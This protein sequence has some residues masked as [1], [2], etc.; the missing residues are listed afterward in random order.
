ML[1]THR[2]HGRWA[3]GTTRRSEAL[4]DWE[5]HPGGMPRKPAIDDGKLVQVN[6]DFEKGP[7]NGA[8]QAL[9]VVAA[10]ARGVLGD[11]QEE[12]RCSP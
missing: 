8:E 2:R 4:L 12:T 7:A 9:A 6:G 10:V 3:G 5:D 1:P 11:M